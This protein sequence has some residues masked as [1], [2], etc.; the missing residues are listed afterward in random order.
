L[1]LYYAESEMD[2]EKAIELYAN[3][4]LTLVSAGKVCEM[5]NIGYDISPAIVTDLDTLQK[6]LINVIE[7]IRT[8]KYNEYIVNPK[9]EIYEDYK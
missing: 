8:Q 5:I 1:D 4:G 2:E 7:N 3:R 9:C 6:H